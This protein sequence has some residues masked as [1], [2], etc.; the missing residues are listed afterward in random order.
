MARVMSR[1]RK[2]KDFFQDQKIICDQEPKL[3]FAAKGGKNA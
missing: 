1:L 3:I 2:K